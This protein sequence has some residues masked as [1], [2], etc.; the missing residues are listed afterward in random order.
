MD[1][2]T[3]VIFAFFLFSLT[4]CVTV[5]KIGNVCRGTKMVGW[6]K[7]EDMDELDRWTLESAKKGCK[8]RFDGKSPC[9]VRL[10]LLPP[11]KNGS[12]QYYAE[13]GKPKGE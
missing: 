8:T 3:K 4:S 13:C 10:V 12:K 11:D 5:V 1:S 9:L 2:K 6:E 7:P